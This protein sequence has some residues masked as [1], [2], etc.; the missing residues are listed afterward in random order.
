VPLF[1]FLLTS[2]TNACDRNRHNS[3]RL[4]LYW[5]CLR[6]LVT[7]SILFVVRPNAT[8]F[9]MENSLPRTDQVRNR[10]DILQSFFYLSH[11]LLLLLGIEYSWNVFPSTDRSS[12]ILNVSHAFVLAG[13]WFGY[14]IG[15][16]RRK[17]AFKEQI[18][19]QLG[20]NYSS[21]SS[22]EPEISS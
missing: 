17:V 2:P 20:T 15:L 11:R 19:I 4:Q 22:T 21:D 13:L 1:A 16:Q 7:L 10:N 18:Q 3:L 12:Y 9:I 5:N 8:S 14:P 6:P